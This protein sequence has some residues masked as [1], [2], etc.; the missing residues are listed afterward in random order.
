MALVRSHRYS[1]VTDRSMQAT[2]EM[3]TSCQFIFKACAAEETE[4]ERLDEGE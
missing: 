1:R 4:S 2:A 3:G